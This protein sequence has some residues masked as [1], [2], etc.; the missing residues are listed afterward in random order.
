MKPINKYVL[1]YLFVLSVFISSC[2]MKTDTTQEQHTD[3]LII[4]PI[5][6]VQEGNIAV[7]VYDFKSFKHF[8]H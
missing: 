6:T 1:L 7:D 5:R 4:K 2:D 8:L 3:S